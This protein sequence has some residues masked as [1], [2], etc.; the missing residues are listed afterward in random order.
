M[1]TTFLLVIW[2]VISFLVVGSL[3]D[4]FDHRLTSKQKLHK[5]CDKKFVGLNKAFHHTYEL[6][7]FPGIII[8]SILYTI[9]FII[10]MLIDGLVYGFNLT[11]KE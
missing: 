3:L 1:S 11:F 4:T 9:E 5:V 8:A 6:F 7:I 10:G 2:G